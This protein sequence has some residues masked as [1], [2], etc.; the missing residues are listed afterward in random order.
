MGNLISKLGFFPSNPVFTVDQIPDLSGQV[1]IVTGGNT[2][3]GKATCKA[4]LEKNAKVYLAARS[5]TKADEAIEWLKTETGKMAVFLQLDLA[6]LVSVRKAV[7]EFKSNE[8]ELH[9]LFNNA[10]IVIPPIDQRTVEGYDLSFGT[11]VLGHFFLTVLLLPTLIHTA[12]ESPTARGH[13]RVINTS[14]GAMWYPP[15]GGIVWETLGTD[16]ASLAACKRLGRPSLY[17]QSKLGNVLFSNELARRYANQGIISV[18]LHPGA[19]KTDMMRYVPIPNW[20]KNLIM[21]L[22]YYPAS[23]GA[24]TQLYA[25]TTPN[26]EDLNGKFLV[27]WAKVGDPGQTAKDERLAGKLWTWCEE[28]IGLFER[29]ME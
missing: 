19:I 7:E 23:Q 28:Q 15:K 13:A 18:S 10:G 3:I 9:V 25:G 2:G 14:S 16:E 20:L 5:K 17:A 21:N 6:S 12:K 11:N 24:L 29:K 27:P 1:V 22:F 8:H 4:L 26:P